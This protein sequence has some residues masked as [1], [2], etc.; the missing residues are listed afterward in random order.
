MYQV[1]R[2]FHNYFV[3]DNTGTMAMCTNMENAELI[4]NALNAAA[5][6]QPDMRDKRRKKLDAIAMEE[7]ADPLAPK[8]GK[9]E[10]KPCLN[11]VCNCY[12]AMTGHKTNCSYFANDA[13]AFRCDYYIPNPKGKAEEEANRCDGSNCDDGWLLDG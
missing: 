4:C 11:R 1:K 9:G 7:T 10:L 8:E 3:G 12:R 2:V 5:P 6:E 13:D